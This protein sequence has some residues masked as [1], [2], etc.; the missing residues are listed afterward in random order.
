LAGKERE[1]KRGKRERENS[2]PSSLSFFLRSLP[3]LGAGHPGRAPP[4]QGEPQPP[5]PPSPPSP[6]PSSPG[7]RL[8]CDPQTRR[9]PP[10]ASSG[11]PPP[12]GSAFQGTNPP[13]MLFWG[14]FSHGKGSVR[15]RIS[16]S[17]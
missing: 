8:R 4:D 9:H 1:R 3:S 11:L 13:I 6:S 5:A 16:Y 12:P 15:E 7:L 14:G 17:T 2:S 10:A